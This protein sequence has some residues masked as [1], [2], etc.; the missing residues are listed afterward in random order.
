MEEETKGQKLTPPM[1]IECLKWDTIPALSRTDIF[2]FGRAYRPLEKPSSLREQVTRTFT[3]LKEDALYVPT[4]AELSALFGHTGSWAESM[5]RSH[6]KAGNSET[7]L[8][9]GRP[10]ITSD[11]QELDLLKFIRTCY[12][13]KCPPTKSQI[14]AYM[15]TRGVT[16]DRHWILRFVERHSEDVKL[17][18]ATY[19][20]AAR[21]ELEWTSIQAYF[22]ALKVGLTG[23]DPRFVYN[24]DE[25]RVHVKNPAPKVDVL[26]PAEAESKNLTVAEVED[27]TN[28]SLVGAISASGSALKP[29]FISTR[30]TY[31][32]TL[33][34]EGYVI[35]EDFF[36]AHTENSF[37]TEK[38]FLDW[39]FRAFLP[40]VTKKAQLTG[41]TG[42]FAILL[43]GHASHGTDIVRSICAQYN[44]TLILLVP[45]SS[46]VAQPLDLLTFG[47]FKRLFS[48]IAAPAGAKGESK[49]L[50]RALTAWAQASH[51][52]ANI[53]AFVRAGIRFV[54]GK[55]WEISPEKV[56]YRLF[57]ECPTQVDIPPRTP[58]KRIPI[59][60]LSN[61]LINFDQ[62]KKISTKVCPFCS[63]PLT[64][65][66]PPPN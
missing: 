1:S 37:I 15:E 65:S 51:K 34:E 39:F 46:H 32:S 9:R 58:I 8:P 31:D 16:I 10:R 30:V 54:C 12:G 7:P 66:E 25:T 2:A 42:K 26:I 52:H 64:V 41:Y 63:R 45:H 22:E 43:D 24:V 3:L 29:Y 5:M 33:H 55:G 59:P 38:V 61:F 57:P 48:R 23:I 40:K 20:E 27:G 19:M 13:R 6:A 36:I 50:F 53:N 35:G 17:A 56:H 18:A 4:I 21:H 47:S 62:L 14:I 11:P 28:L 49:Y 44:T 60:P